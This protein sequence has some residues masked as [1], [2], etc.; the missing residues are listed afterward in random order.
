MADPS[1]TSELPSLAFLFDRN[2]WRLRGLQSWQDISLVGRANLD[3][4]LDLARERAAG[5]MHQGSLDRE[6]LTALRPG[7]RYLEALARDTVERKPVLPRVR[8]E[9]FR[10]HDALEIYLGDSPGAVAK[11]P[12]LKARAVAVDKAHN[13][14]WVTSERNSG[15]FWQI[16][17]RAD[18]EIF[19]DTD[20]VRFSTSEPRALLAEE[21]CL[22]RDEVAAS[23]PFAALW[24]ENAWRAWSPMWCLERGTRIDPLGVDFV[25]WLR[26]DPQLAREG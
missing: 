24:C 3:R 1:G 8:V 14:A 18:C 15:Y 21:I 17:A 10:P 25:R 9:H 16:T 26:C 4:L 22:L 7:L 2:A 23:T 13:P 12:W 11:M 5:A 6:E 19:P 20:M